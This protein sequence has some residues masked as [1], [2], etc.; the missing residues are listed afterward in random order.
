MKT[1]SI[2][3]KELK[4][5]FYHPMSYIITAVFLLLTGW[6]FSN[7]LFIVRVAEL[8]NL[9]NILPFLLLFLI[10]AITMKMVAEEKRLGTIE[11]ILTNPI[12]DSS[13]ILGKFFASLAITLFIYL[14]TLYYVLVLVIAGEPDIGKI[15]ASYIGIILLTSAYISIGIFAST[16]T[17]NQIVSF[18]VSFMIIFI[19]FLTDKVSLFFPANIQNFLNDI[20][21]T[22]HF[23]YFTLGVMNIWDVTYYVSL[24][25]LFLYLAY[26]KITERYF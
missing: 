16:I 4:I 19:L 9:L 1:Y 3:S 22:G 17:N 11:L 18:I 21:I 7:S 20:S 12:K 13:F 14:L 26:Y 5:F 6:F 24:I 10:P 25:I 23:N 8:T 15:V 2:I